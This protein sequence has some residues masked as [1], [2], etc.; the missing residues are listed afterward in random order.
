MSNIQNR[1]TRSSLLIKHWRSM[2]F[3]YSLLNPRT[4]FLSF[5]SL[6][7]NETHSIKS[8]RLGCYH[9][10]RLT[11]G[12]LFD[13]SAIIVFSAHSKKKKTSHRFVCSAGVRASWKTS[14]HCI[15]YD[16]ILVDPTTRLRVSK[17]YVL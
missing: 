16:E 13:L 1:K 3:T 12:S 7:L 14:R 17:L 8:N 11:R 10:I 15:S 5:S 6:V 2:I 4:F 9:C